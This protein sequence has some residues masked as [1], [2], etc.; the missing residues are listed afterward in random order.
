MPALNGLKVLDLTR[1]RAEPA[2]CHVLADLVLKS[3]KLKR[4]RGWILMQ[5]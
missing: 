3:L 2:C 5:A 4:Q 1:V